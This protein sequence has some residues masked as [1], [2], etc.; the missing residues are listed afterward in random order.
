[1][2]IELL[3]EKLSHKDEYIEMLQ[4]QISF[5]TESLQSRSD[6]AFRTST[7]SPFVKPPVQIRDPSPTVGMSPSSSQNIPSLRASS[8][9]PLSSP[10]IGNKPS[11]GPTVGGQ[12]S[13]S[14]QS[15]SPPTRVYATPQTRSPLQASDIPITY[16]DAV[17]S[18]SPPPVLLRRTPVRPSPSAT[19]QQTL[20]AKHQLH[21]I[22]F[23]GLRQSKLSVFRQHAKQIGLSLRS[24]QNISFV[25]PSIVELL[26]DVTEMQSFIDQAKSLGFKVKSD[27]DIAVA[28]KHHPLWLEKDSGTSNFKEQVRSNFLTRIAHEIK[29]AANP[30]AKEYYLDWARIMK[31]DESISSN[32]T[33]RRSS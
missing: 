19:R 30:R 9:S 11:H 24:V 10:I 33:P 2:K 16:S 5:L 32:S 3:V 7:R 25:G 20:K 15:S 26:V 13:S 4:T 27:L 28:D 29:S 14:N 8:I 22:Y 18:S 1:M 21:T 12:Q 23:L 17:R 31:V 6:R